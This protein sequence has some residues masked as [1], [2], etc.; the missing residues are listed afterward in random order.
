MPQS[1]IWNPDRT[2]QYPGIANFAMQ[3]QLAI[4][5]AHDSMIAARVKQTRAANRKRQAAPFEASDLVY[6]STK[7]IKFEK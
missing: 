6:L 4:M 1:L 2:R 5:S 7:N 3:Q